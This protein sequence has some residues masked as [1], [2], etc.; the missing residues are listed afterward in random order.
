MTARSFNRGHEIEFD[1]DQDK[2]VYSGTKHVVDHLH[3][4]S[5]CGKKPIIMEINRRTRDVDRCIAP[6]VKALNEAGVETVACCCGHKRRPGNIILKDGREVFIMP[7]F[8]S[9][10]KIDKLFPPLFED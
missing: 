10:R 4:C 5:G 6:I 1:E 7:N 2:W 8:E 9:A 3:Y